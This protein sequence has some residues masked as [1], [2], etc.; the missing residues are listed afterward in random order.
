MEP[1][2]QTSAIVEHRLEQVVVAMVY[3]AAIGSGMSCSYAPPGVRLFRLKEKYGRAPIA[4]R[5]VASQ[6][7][8][9]SSP[10][11]S[12][13]STPLE[14]PVPGVPPTHFLVRAVLG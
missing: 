3:G 11:R 5:S 12:P 8:T 13:F 6:R 10:L 2:A 1:R 9:V 14:I 7:P 4:P